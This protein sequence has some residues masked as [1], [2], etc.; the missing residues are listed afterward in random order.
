MSPGQVSG[1]EEVKI[2][3]DKTPA[4]FA[5]SIFG[6]MERFPA[7]P[8][9]HLLTEQQIKELKRDFLAVAVPQAEA[10]PREENG[11][12]NKYVMLWAVATA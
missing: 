3:E 9:S 7:A 8:L 5:E 6:M 11:I 4:Q 10:M 1:T 12:A 2:F